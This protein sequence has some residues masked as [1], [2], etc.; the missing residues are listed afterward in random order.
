M[1]CDNILTFV[2]LKLQMLIRQHAWCHVMFVYNILVMFCLRFH[3]LNGKK[4]KI[5]YFAIFCSPPPQT[6]KIHVL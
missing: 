2:I 5:Y 1:S 3:Q 6:S 4:M